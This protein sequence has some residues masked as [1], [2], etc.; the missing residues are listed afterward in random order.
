MFG[1]CAVTRNWLRRT[2][3][4]I[5]GNSR[6]RRNS[7]SETD[8]EKQAR[9]DPGMGA[10]RGHDMVRHVRRFCPPPMAQAG[11]AG[12]VQTV[13]VIDF[14]NKSGVGGD[15]LARLATDAVAVEMAN[16]PGLRS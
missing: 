13:I 3:E 5:Y 9:P 7:Q 15:A 11:A 6:S 10:E 1:T 8:R 14:V 4:V 12:G 16:S 2:Y